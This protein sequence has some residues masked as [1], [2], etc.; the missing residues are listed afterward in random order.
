MRNLP[1]QVDLRSRYAAYGLEPRAQGRRGTCSLFALVGVLEFER[2]ATG[3]ARP[4]ER[5]SVE[6]LNWASH[7]TNGRRQDGSFFSD[8]L[9]GLRRFGICGESLLPY[10]ESYDADAAPPD[11]ALRDAQKR[12]TDFRVHWIKEWDVKTGLTEEHLTAIRRR[13]AEGHPVAAGMRWPKKAT[14]APG[15][16]LI[17]HPPPRDVFDGHSVVLVGYTDDPGLPGGGAFLFRN[18]SGPD[19]EEG[20]YARISYAYARDYVNDAVAVTLGGKQ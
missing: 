5:L 10:A 19:W 6:F 16:R 12:R 17:V 11:A 20:G 14:F 8:A 3:G 1:R 13:L 7:Q 4:G 15:T 18:S 2:A 9:E